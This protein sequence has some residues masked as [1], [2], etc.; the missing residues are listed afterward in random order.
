[1]KK[2]TLNTTTEG[3]KLQ[4]VYDKNLNLYTIFMI[5]TKGKSQT[6]PMLNKDQAYELINKKTTPEAEPL[7]P[8]VLKAIGIGIDPSTILGF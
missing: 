4:V 3:I 1:M 8:V 5:S 7:S 6:F 2:I